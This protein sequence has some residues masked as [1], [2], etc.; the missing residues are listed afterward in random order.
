MRVLIVGAGAVGGYFGGR[1]MEAGRD[2][3]FL[4]RPRRRDQ[5]AA[6]GLVIKS[7]H[8][9]FAAPARTVLA[10]DIAA[11][12]DLA[13]LSCKAYDLAGAMDSLAPAVGPDSTVLPLLNGMRHL[14]ALAERF[15]EG[16]VMGGLCSLVVTLTPEG[17]VAHSSPMHDLVFG[18]RGG[19]AS[20]M[21]PVA[22]L[23]GGANFAWRA[24]PDIVLEMWEKWVFLATLAGMTCL[25]RASVGDIVASGGGGTMLALLAEARS[26]AAAAGHAPRPEVLETYRALLTAP[27]S[28]MTASMLRDLEKGGAVE[29]DH[30]IGD[31]IRRGEAAGLDLPLLRLAALHLAAYQA[32]RSRA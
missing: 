2:V 9:D 15:G 17:H 16:K 27:G 7:P 26:V 25:M 14:D 11:P 20:R 12:F 31:L 3:T 6:T 28:A 19:G 24:S 30:V 23:F 32:R 13:I 22:E 10:E 21:A 5:L 18:E 1:L 8:G 4:V 29:A